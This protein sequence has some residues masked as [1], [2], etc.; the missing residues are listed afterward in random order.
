VQLKS[1]QVKST[2]VQTVS[3]ITKIIVVK[4]DTFLTF[5]YLYHTGMSRL[6]AGIV[7]YAERSMG[8]FRNIIHEVPALYNNSNSVKLLS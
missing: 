6:K 7:F 3:S 5:V 2:K 1:R 8:R 4:E